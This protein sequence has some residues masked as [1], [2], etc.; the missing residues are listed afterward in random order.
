[1]RQNIGLLLL[2]LGSILLGVSVFQTFLFTWINFRWKEQPWE[3]RLYCRM[4]GIRNDKDYFRK[5]AAIKTG[6]PSRQDKLSLFRRLFYDLPLVAV[7]LM[8]IG[9]FLS[10]NYAAI[11]ALF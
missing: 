11:I 8:I 1:M 9:F 5:L 2:T 4:R 7:G 10:L 3:V 6:L